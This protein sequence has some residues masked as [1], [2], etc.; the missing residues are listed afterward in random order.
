MKLVP[1]TSFVPEGG[2]AGPYPVTQ[3]WTWSM[4]QSRNP[5]NFS[6]TPGSS[7]FTFT[8]GATS[9]RVEAFSPGIAMFATGNGEIIGFNETGGN[10]F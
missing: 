3:F 7:Y 10:E 9:L 1:L 6:E 5:T 8:N 2:F 4:L